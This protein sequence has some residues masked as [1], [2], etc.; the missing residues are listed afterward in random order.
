MEANVAGDDPVVVPTCNGR[1]ATIVGSS[2]TILGTPGEDVIV[3]TAGEDNIYAGAGNDTICGAA[4]YDTIRPGLGNDWVDG[5]AGGNAIDYSDS[6]HGVDVDLSAGVGDEDQLRNFDEVFGSIHND[7]LVGDDAANFLA[8]NLGDDAIEGRGGS[9]LI[10]GRSSEVPTA[11]QSDSDN[12]VPGPG[13]DRV[14]AHEGDDHI[15]AVDGSRDE[16]TCGS[17]NDTGAVDTIDQRAEDCEALTAPGVAEPPPA[18]LCPN[19]DGAQSALPSGTRLDSA[20]NC[21]GPSRATATLRQATAKWKPLA[22]GSTAKNQCVQRR[23]VRLVGDVSPDSG[24]TGRPVLIEVQ[25]RAAGRWPDRPA[26][27][28]KLG[29]GQRVRMVHRFAGGRWRMRLLMPGTSGTARAV[30]AW[31]YARTSGG[32]R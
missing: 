23:P 27:K 2:T 10:W 11:G 4:G 5:G 24:L 30:S 8:G 7:R 9:D 25:R 28:A 32:D 13:T 6:D 17:G 19:L 1:T 14:F 18:D 16:I 21:V 20:G 15:D 3:G 29:K 26:L 31:Q 22:C 12:I